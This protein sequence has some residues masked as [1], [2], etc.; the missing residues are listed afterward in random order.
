LI[1]IR[2]DMQKTIPLGV[3]LFFGQHTTNWGVIF[4]ALTL[5]CLPPILIYIAFSKYFIQGITA[6]AVKG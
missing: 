4:S 3:A 5:A 2:S 6:G 1:F